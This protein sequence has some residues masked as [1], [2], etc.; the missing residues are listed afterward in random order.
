MRKPRSIVYGVD[1][2]PPAGITALSAFQHVVQIALRLV[3][4][5]LVAREAGLG[6]E[7]VTDV[8]SVSLV[9]VGLTTIAQ[10]LRWGPLGSGFLCPA[11][12]TSA[13]IAPSLLAARTGGMPLVLGMT[14]F[15]GVLEILL[16]RAVRPLRPFVPPEL[17]GFVVVMVGIAVGSVGTRSVLGVGAAHGVTPV[18]FGVTV[19]TLAAMIALNV[20]TRGLT[21]ILCALLGMTV[22]YVAAAAAGLLTGADLAPMLAAPVVNVPLP[23]L[24]GWAFDAGLA[25]AFAVAALAACLR[26]I[27]DVTTCQKINDADWVRPSMG[28]LAG[29]VLAN[30]VGT[31]SAGLLGSIGV[32][33]LTS[34]VGLASATGVTSRRVA[35][36][37]GGMLLALAFTPKVSALVTI[38]PRPVLG[39]VLWFSACFIVVNGLQIVTSRMLDV[40][41][42][43][44]I[45]LGFTVGLAVD[46]FPAVFGAFPAGVQAFTGSSLVLGTLTAF[47]LNVLFRIGV[48]RRV[49]LRVDPAAV[50]PRRIEEFLEERGA[51]WGARRDVIDRARFN[52]AQAVETIV[53]GCEPQG[54]LTVE[55]QFDEFS[56]DLRVSYPGAALELPERRP[57]NEE[58]MAAEDGTRR[59]AGFLLRRQADRVQSSH[60]GGLATVHFHFDH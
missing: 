5:L 11:A 50:E 31:L 13:Y 22:G 14:V 39:A 35:W 18:E 24:G 55:A 43:F 17:A 21:R 34:G 60:R 42:T 47:L 29:G 49:T 9:V 6:P 7:Q 20:W 58:I 56:L 23:H 4:P 25:V 10:S 16:S 30:G 19:L 26:S 54:P 28:S 48:R 2:V 52:L 15:G 46:L 36:A 33:T 44:V 51:E 27:G 45:G 1:D 37:T 12:F 53:D 41:R 40:R 57:S 3:F 38:M 59:L 8:M 32:N